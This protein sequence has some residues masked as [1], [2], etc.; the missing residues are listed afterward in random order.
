MAHVPSETSPPASLTSFRRGTL[1]FEVD[2]SGPRTGPLDGET[3]VLLH[4]FPADK[5]CWVDVSARLQEQGLRTLAP[6][7]RGYSPRARPRRRTAYATSELVGDV[8]ALLDAAGV[9]KAH[10]VGHDWGGAVAWTLAGAHPDRV[11]SVTV[12]STPHP[13]AL[14]QAYRD[15]WQARHSAY[16]AWF[17]LPVLPELL[18]DRTMAPG[19]RRSS[20]P[21]EV[22]D[23]YLAKM[24]EPG[25]LSATIGW[26]RGMPFSRGSVHRCRVP[27]TLVWGS[28]D[29][30]LGRTAAETTERFV[31]GDYRFVELDEGHWLPE[32][33]P[34]ACA[35]EILR[36]VRSAVPGATGA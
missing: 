33:A 24:R 27:A 1:T 22:A 35:Q 17:Q 11:A 34:D 28:R 8:V 25:R 20:L 6:E 2:D 19:L 32:V 4:G 3:V 5:E 30:F 7:Q 21:A 13:A 18:F 26:Y 29:P 36:R 12:L 9:E 31:L 16:M 23:R 14:S 10:V 15:P